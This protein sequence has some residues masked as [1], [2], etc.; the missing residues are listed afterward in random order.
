MA[1]ALERA[2]AL[3]GKRPAILDQEGEM[4]W[5]VY[6]GRI[7][8]A[9]GVLQSLGLRP[10]QR[11]GIIS[12]NSFRHAELIHAG[13]WLGAVPVPVNFRLA[14]PEIHYILEDAACDLIAVE[15]RFVHLLDNE[16]FAPWRKRALYVAPQPTAVALPQYETLL[17][18]TGP[19]A[20]HGAN[21][22]DDAILLYTGGTTGRSKGVRLSH[23]NLIANGIQFGLA[24]RAYAGDR[25]LHVA[26][27][28][29][30]A[31]L[32]GTTFTLVGGAHIYLSEFSGRN[33]LQAVRDHRVTVCNLPPTT[34]IVTLQESD[35]DRF[36]V[37]SLRLLVYGSAPMAPEWIQRAMRKFPRAE[38]QQAYG[39]TETSPMLT[40]LSPLEHK[41]AIE[42]G[43]LELLRSVGKP[44]VQVELRVVDD[45]DRELPAGETGEIVVRG[46]NVTKGYLGLPELNAETF[47]NGWFHSGDVGRLDEEGNL[48]IL[49]RKKDVIITG[50]EN[51]YCSE[52]EAAL[53]KHPGIH[54]AAVFGVP[55][56]KWGE[57]VYAAIVP[58]SG[59]ALRQEE[60][61]EHCRQYIGGYKIP[62]RMAF[63]EALPKTALGKVLRTE[64][65]R[66]Y[67][68]PDRT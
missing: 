42:T 30:S 29:H 19:A 13:Y 21:Q 8:R 20:I 49:D 14:V 38:L 41:R 11:Y 36:D 64:L 12:R 50:S 56:E 40:A 31:D 39:L 66:M 59:Y 22:D 32:V 34:I 2:A 65:R 18:D 3:F 10:G 26:P 25:Y 47:R 23:A 58:A 16:A 5:S 6:V 1:T 46:P 54:E 52:V 44:L 33:F 60:I 24:T 28:F 43:N 37:T 61:I 63:V 55:D 62:R 57:A 27:M 53:Y 48:Y 67:G 35:F 7:A 51:V 45:A 9:A 68:D 4:L 17:A 15:D